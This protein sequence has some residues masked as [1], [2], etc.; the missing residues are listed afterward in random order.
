MRKRDNVIIN[1]EKC[2]QEL[3]VGV[4]CSQ[5]LIPENT[6]RSPRGCGPIHVVPAYKEF[7]VIFID[8]NSEKR[9]GWY[10]EYSLIKLSQKMYKKT[11]LDDL[12]EGTKV[13]Y[14]GINSIVKRIVKNK[15]GEIEA[16]IFDETGQQV[17][18]RSGEYSFYPGIL[19]CA[20]ELIII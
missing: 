13:S 16:E 17:W 2:Y 15:N 5:R 10:S 19:P 3:G 1:N 11:M 9:Y 14:F 8:S 20:A 4:I 6:W 12:I 18:K 7:F